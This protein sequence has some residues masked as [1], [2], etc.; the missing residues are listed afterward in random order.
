MGLVKGQPLTVRGLE[1]ETRPGRYIDGPNSNG[2]SNRIRSRKNGSLSK[3][4]YWRGQIQNKG[5]LC[6][7]PKE[8]PLGPFGVVSL[9]D[10][11]DMAREY[12]RLALAGKDPRGEEPEP[13]RIPT[14]T[15]ATEAVIVL[16][17]Y[18]SESKKPDEWR[19]TFR[20][21]VIDV[22]GDKG[23]DEITRADILS[24]IGPLWHDEQH[25]ANLLL[26]R[27][28]KVLTWAVGQGFRE[29]NPADAAAISAL[30]P[31]RR[32]SVKH[33][34][35]DYR[36]VEDYIREIRKC[37]SIDPAL[38]AGFEFLVLTLGRH[39]EIF[40]SEWTDL[41]MDHQVFNPKDKS[42]PPMKFPCLVIPAE[43]MK[44]KTEPHVIPLSIQALQV[45]V[46]ALEFRNRH[47]H[48]IFP[49]ET[50]GTF[51]GGDTKRVR[52]MIVIAIGTAHGFR[53]SFASWGQDHV[54]PE[55][56]VEMALAHTVSGVRGSYARSV[57]LSRRTYLMMDWADYNSGRFS[58]GYLWSERFVPEDVT[59]YPDLPALSPDEWA[60]LDEPASSS[61]SAFTLFD[62]VQQAYRAIHRSHD[63]SSARL[64][65][66]FMALTASAP[67]VVRRARRSEIDLENGIWT[68]PDSHNPKS[69]QNFSVPLSTAARSVVV[70]AERIGRSSS[71]L[72]PSETGDEITNTD[73]NNLFEVLNLDIKPWHFKAAFTMWCE[74][75]GVDITLVREL[76]GRKQAETLA[77]IAKRDTSKEQAKLLRAWGAFLAGRQSSTWRWSE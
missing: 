50:G 32:T 31:V 53:A 35:V 60:A 69:G 34:A 28:A 66:Q 41:K 19:S 55:D 26:A 77:P 6:E 76:C 47:P 12:S 63:D 25:Q 51:R 17:E 33:A 36:D 68:V 22:I 42:L 29:Y 67:V 14:L 18:S 11:R 65:A 2:L 40:D 21:F 39:K 61:N 5:E 74:E 48:R 13:I 16:Q 49:T 75:A 23:V 45:L 64:A 27:M 43:R 4:F 72:F 44:T 54:V 8:Y 38:L 52:D 59:T 1:T 10:A 37:L 58:D 3:I 30:P 62:D 57:M 9:T 56:L 7:E 73:L 70:K 20:R 24:I 71:L 15:V 46:R